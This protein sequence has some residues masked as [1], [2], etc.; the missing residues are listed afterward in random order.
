[1]SE[2]TMPGTPQCYTLWRH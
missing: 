1:V 2:M